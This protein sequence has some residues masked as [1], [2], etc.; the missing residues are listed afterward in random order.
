MIGVEQFFS[1]GGKAVKQ[2][3]SVLM[4]VLENVLMNQHTYRIP[5]MWVPMPYAKATDT[6]TP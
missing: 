6:A 1:K 4:Y 3:L 2:A 5:A